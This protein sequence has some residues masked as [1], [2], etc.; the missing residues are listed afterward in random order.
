MKRILC[1]EGILGKSWKS[2]SI[3]P[4]ILGKKHIEIQRKWKE[5]NNWDGKI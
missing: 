3:Y 4:K 5:K 1:L 2:V